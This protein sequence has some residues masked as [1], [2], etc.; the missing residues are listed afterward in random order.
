M[1]SRGVFLIRTLL[2]SQLAPQDM[3]LQLQQLV[4]PEKAKGQDKFINS[5]HLFPCVVVNKVWFS[6][7]TEF[8]CLSFP[9]WRCRPGKRR[10]KLSLRPDTSL[11]VSRWWDL[12]C[13]NSQSGRGEQPQGVYVCL[14]HLLFASFQL[15]FS[16]FCPPVLLRFPYYFTHPSLVY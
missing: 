16:I 2:G 1:S 6:N 15:W 10:W 13:Y 14:L 4:W 8:F 9:G 12:L 5:K 3:S 11:L 7:N